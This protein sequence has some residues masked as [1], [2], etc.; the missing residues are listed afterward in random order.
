MS[1]RKATKSNLIVASG[2]N[3]RVEFDRTT[4]DYSAI[5]EGRYI[6]SEK[7]PSAAQSLCHEYLYRQ[8]APVA[9]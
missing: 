3:W 2:A 7:T 4:R 5:V 1:N 6:G 9:A 8:L